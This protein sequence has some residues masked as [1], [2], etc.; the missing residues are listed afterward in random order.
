MFHYFTL[1][2]ITI[3]ITKDIIC[4]KSISGMDSL[5]TVKLLGDSVSVWYYLSS[6]LDT[7]N[8]Y[9]YLHI[10]TYIYT[11]LHTQ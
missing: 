5:D 8:I 7:E 3:D 4:R 9:T 10:S 11:Y 1:D 2:T 6:D